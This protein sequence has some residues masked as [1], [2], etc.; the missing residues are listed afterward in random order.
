MSAALVKGNAARGPVW[1]VGQQR[2]THKRNML[3]GRAQ[4]AAAA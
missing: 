4:Q 2:D 1:G 3:L